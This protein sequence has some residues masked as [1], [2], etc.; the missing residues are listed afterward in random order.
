MRKLFQRLVD[1]LSSPS[2]LDVDD[3]G[4]SKREGCRKRRLGMSF[5]MRLS[6]SPMTSHARSEWKGLSATIIVQCIAAT[7]QISVQTRLR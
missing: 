6:F 2:S 4:E 5:R 1:I 7:T 3:G